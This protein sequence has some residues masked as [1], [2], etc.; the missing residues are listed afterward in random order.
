MGGFWV[1]G[2]EERF[3][4]GVAPD[5]FS[6][7]LAY[8]NKQSHLNSVGQKIEHQSRR[9]LL[10]RT[11]MGEEGGGKVTEGMKFPKLG[12]HICEIVDNKKNVQTSHCG[13]IAND[14]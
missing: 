4:S 11:A 5:K 13:E 14:I 8:S 12:R 2:G 3:F 9:S 10:R 7:F 1:L 6:M